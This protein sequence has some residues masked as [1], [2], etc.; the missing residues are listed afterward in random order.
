MGLGHTAGLIKGWS[1]DLRPLTRLHRLGARHWECCFVATHPA[2]I[3]H[4]LLEPSGHAVTHHRQQALRRQLVRGC[5]CERP[6]QQEAGGHSRRHLLFLSGGASDSLSQTVCH[7]RSG[8]TPAPRPHCPRAAHAEKAR[9]FQNSQPHEGQGC[10]HG[11]PR[12]V[13]RPQEKGKCLL[14][15]EQRA[16]RFRLPWAPRI[17]ELAL[18]PRPIS[19]LLGEL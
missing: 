10:G 19:H 1:L 15:F 14:L 6:S 18:P 12:Q 11:K 16:L 3:T 4:P 17:L 8:L 13:E 9:Y 7:G 5:R 2:L